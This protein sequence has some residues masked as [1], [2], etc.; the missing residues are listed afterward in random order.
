MPYVPRGRGF[1]DGI[2]RARLQQTD[3][4]L[5][6]V[7]R[8]RPVVTGEAAD[9]TALGWSRSEKALAARAFVEIDCRDLPV[10]PDGRQY[11]WDELLAR[12]PECRVKPAR[13]QVVGQV[14][15]EAPALQTPPVRVAG[16]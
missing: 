16:V 4:L 14:I 10:G 7:R 11:R 13:G 15:V 12:H 9:T 2:S 3:L 6:A 5:S 1:G 8:L